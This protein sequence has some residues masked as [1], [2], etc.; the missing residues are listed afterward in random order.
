MALQLRRGTDSERLLITPV[1]G[2]LI[3][4]TDDKKL[5]AGDGTTAGGVEV[6]GGS[7][8]LNALTDT[9]LTVPTALEDRNHNSD[10]T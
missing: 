5:Y 2:E 3:Y 1:I 8:T 4:T 7:S 6:G 9:D 10:C